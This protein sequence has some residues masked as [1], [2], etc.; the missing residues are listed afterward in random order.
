MLLLG[1]AEYCDTK[2]IVIP[3]E[4][5]NLLLVEFG[6]Q[7]IPRAKKQALGMTICWS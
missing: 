3:S 7:Q 5:R 6:K 4:A 2:W 1:F